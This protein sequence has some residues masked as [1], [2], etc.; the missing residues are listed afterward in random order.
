L[1]DPVALKIYIFTD[2]L[3]NSMINSIESNNNSMMSHG[4]SESGS[5]S[6]SPVQYSISPHAVSLLSLRGTLSIKKV[7]HLLLYLPNKCGK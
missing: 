4:N 5:A 6:N 1:L 7:T 3:G 2:I